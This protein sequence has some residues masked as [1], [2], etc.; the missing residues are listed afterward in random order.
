MDRVHHIMVVDGGSETPSNIAF[1]LQLSGFRVSEYHDELEACNWLQQQE[2]LQQAADMLL[3][4]NPRSGRTLYALL[5]QIRQLFPQLEILFVAPE[6]LELVGQICQID[7]PLRQCSS[8]EVH[9]LTRRIYGVNDKKTMA[10]KPHGLINPA[11]PTRPAERLPLAG[12][13]ER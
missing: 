2:G 6:A 11:S 7:P 1:L 5:F 4:N 8:A 13:E 9:G 10:P 3:L 12:Q